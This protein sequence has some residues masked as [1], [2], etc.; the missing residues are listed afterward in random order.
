MANI[1]TKR[2]QEAK[3]S[4]NQGNVDLK[5]IYI[6]LKDG[7]SVRVRLLGVHDYVEYL[8]VGDFNLG[9]YTQPSRLPLGEDDAFDEAK[10]IADE[11]AGDDEE[12]EL[13][14]FQR[15]YPKKRYVFAFAD[16]DTGEV[17]V[18]DCSKNQ[19]KGIIQSIEEYAEDITEVAFTFKR[20]GDGRET[21]YTLNPI[22]RLKGDDQEKFDAFEETVVED[23]LFNKVLIARTYEQ[24]VEALK[25]AGFPVEDYFEVDSNGENEGQP[26]GE[27]SEDP[28]GDF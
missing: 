27:G 11:L 12:H 13:A 21:S 6:R 14:P 3:E 20:T 22:L 10:K 1:F 23:E 2:G 28:T 7:E 4:M 16:I 17:R 19:A 8:A 24:Q 26:E 18:W 25:N 5:K 9:V 15:L